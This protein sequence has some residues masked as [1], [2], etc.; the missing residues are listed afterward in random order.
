MIVTESSTSKAMRFHKAST[1]II[2]MTDRLVRSPIPFPNNRL[3]WIQAVQPR[4]KGK[5]SP[6]I[7]QSH[8]HF[9]GRIS[10]INNRETTGGAG[11][12]LSEKP[13]WNRQLNT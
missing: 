7:C 3:G 13:S 9:R 8:V 1:S 11:S 2:L 4:K 5:N 10:I 12:F 6:E